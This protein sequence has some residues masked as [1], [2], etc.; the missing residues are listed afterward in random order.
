[1]SGR[2]VRRE[3]Q[4]KRQAGSVRRR[5]AATSSR[6]RAQRAALMTGWLRSGLRAYSHFG[7][8]SPE[9]SL[10]ATQRGAE[11]PH[12]EPAYSAAPRARL[13]QNRAQRRTATACSV[14]LRT[15][16]GRSARF[17]RVGE[18]S[19]THSHLHALA[20]A[21]PQTPAGGGAEVARHPE[22]VQLL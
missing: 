19:L 4:G 1:K 21:L 13:G 9:C 3:R 20:E 17:D 14:A 8:A 5:N 7:P 10:E 22:N 6:G 16:L 12:Q 11:A 2:R 18:G 15:R